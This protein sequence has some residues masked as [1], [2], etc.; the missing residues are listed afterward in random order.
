MFVFRTDEDFINEDMKPF[1]W[2]TNKFGFC[3][4]AVLCGVLLCFIKDNNILLSDQL[5]N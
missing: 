1:S 4:A 3:Y 2:M 5:I